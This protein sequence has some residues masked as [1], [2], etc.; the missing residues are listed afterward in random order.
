MSFHINIID[1]IEELDGAGL[2][3]S[4]IEEVKEELTGMGVSLDT[5]VVYDDCD[6]DLEEQNQ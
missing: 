2:I 6:D 5:E 1:L 4:D 3:I